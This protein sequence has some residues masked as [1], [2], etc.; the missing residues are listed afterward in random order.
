VAVEGE[1][2]EKGKAITAAAQ[3]GVMV[4]QKANST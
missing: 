2:D 3:Q 1:N 4:A